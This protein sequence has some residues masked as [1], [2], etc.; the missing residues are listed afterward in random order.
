MEALDIVVDYF[1][2]SSEIDK[3]SS[4]GTPLVSGYLAR[5]SDC[6]LMIVDHGALTSQM[7]NFLRTAGIEPGKIFVAGLSA[8]YGWARLCRCNLHKY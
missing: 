8:E 1:E 3:D 6:K 4:M 2:I 5:N 7:E